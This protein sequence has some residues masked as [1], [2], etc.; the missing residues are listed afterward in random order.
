MAKFLN[1]FFASLG[2][3]NDF[4]DFGVECSFKS[5]FHR[6]SSSSSSGLIFNHSP[7][8]GR[9]N[10][11]SVLSEGEENVFFNRTNWSA[12]KQRLSSFDTEVSFLQLS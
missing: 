11:H 9:L 5:V 6:N 3:L 8:E 10:V 2:V 1:I 4:R 12:V 7:A